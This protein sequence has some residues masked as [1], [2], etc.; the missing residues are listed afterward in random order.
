MLRAILRCV[1]SGFLP[2][3]SLY[4]SWLFPQLHEVGPRSWSKRINLPPFSLLSLSSS[5]LRFQQSVGAQGCSGPSTG[6]FQPQHL[7]SSCWLKS[8][9]V[10]AVKMGFHFK[11]G[12]T[13]GRG[14]FSALTDYLNYISSDKIFSF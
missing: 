5:L 7:V 8:V 4:N 1:C 9:S 6:T 14:F 11:W 10:L 2:L 13:R 12:E 3:S